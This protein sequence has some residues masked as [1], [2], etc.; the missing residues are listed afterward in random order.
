M[1]AL[2]LAYLSSCSTH[3]LRELQKGTWFL[4]LAENLEL[5]YQ[6]II[7]EYDVKT[8]QRIRERCENESNS[9]HCKTLYRD[10]N[11]TVNIENILENVRDVTTHIRIN[12]YG[13]V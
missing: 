9:I 3:N 12:K 6:Y 13:G 4:K 10:S 1:G 2:V 7:S 8:K 11:F 5:S